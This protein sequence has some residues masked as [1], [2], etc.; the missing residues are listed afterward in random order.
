MEWK[1][2]I[3]EDSL[4]EEQEFDV[5]CMICGIKKKVKAKIQPSFI[6]CESCKNEQEKLWKKPND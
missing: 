2:R 1:D 6:L 5:P 3:R 4:R